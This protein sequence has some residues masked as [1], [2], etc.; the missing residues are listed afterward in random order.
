M[1]D[2]QKATD[3]LKDI[4]SNLGSLEEI[5]RPYEAQ[6]DE[7][8]TYIYHSRRKITDKETTKGLKTG[9]LVYD[10][11]A[12]G[13]VNLLTDGLTGYTI[14][15][16]FNWFGHTLPQQVQYGSVRKRLDEI[17]E[18]KLWLE[19]TA[20]VMYSAYRRSNIYDVATEFVRDAATVGTV[21]INADED[22]AA[23]RVVFSVPHFRECFIAENAFGEVDTNYRVYKLTL[24]QLVEKFG[25]DQMVAAEQ[26]GK[27]QKDYEANRNSEREVIHARFPRKDYLPWRMDG[28]NKPFASIWI[29]RQPEKILLESGTSQQSF[30]TWRWRK[31]TDEWY[32]RSP[33]W[34]AFIDAMTA[35][36]MAKTNLIAGHKMVDPPMIGPSDLRNQVKRA[37]GGWTSYDGDN[38]PQP[39]LEG[40]QL[41][42]GLEL[43]DRFDKKI[44]DHFHVDFFLMLSQA[45]LSGTEMTA[46]QVIEMGGEKAAV[47]GPRIG[48]METEAL[49]KIHDLM[50]S[51][52]ARAR[53]IPP[54]PQI[55]ADFQGQSFTTEYLGPLA[56][57][58][59]K[60]FQ[61][62][63]VQQGLEAI[64]NM[65]Q[66]FPEVLDLVNPT[67]AGKLMLSSRGFPQKAMNDDKTIADIR[68]MKQAAAQQQEQLDSGIAMAKAMPAAGK[69]IAPNSAAGMLLKGA[70]VEAAG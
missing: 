70:G 46:T 37:P 3:L 64:A 11:T 69:E 59:K 65:A 19:D 34:D 26:P 14:S 54:P 7:I 63:G 28:K 4:K 41:P 32:G 1:A 36:Q 6:I 57:A 25:W 61:S 56:Q 47:L 31:N 29:L 16:S 48:R 21:T 43:Q 18:V 17:P 68:Q 9:T 12:L 38:K 30:V 51:I 58:Q 22:I 5:R 45:A 35:N 40:L 42:F 50:F 60:L 13:A 15:R 52:E 55:L 33:A 66:M 44:R 67:E 20:E 2:E 10:G 39:L 27:F 24:K 49:S 8:L 62:Q 23:G 53:R